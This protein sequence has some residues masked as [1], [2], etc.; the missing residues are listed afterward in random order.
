MRVA[1]GA[2]SSTV[3]NVEHVPEAGERP[4]STS[5]IEVNVHCRSEF[6]AIGTGAIPEC[7]PL[8]RGFQT[9]MRTSWVRTPPALKG[10]AFH[11]IGNAKTCRQVSCSAS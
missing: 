6:M 10:M 2:L 11:D 7:Q 8:S 4:T 5:V 3:G 9:L 1:V